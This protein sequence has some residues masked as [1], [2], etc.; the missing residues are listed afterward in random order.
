MAVSP[1]LR[2]VVAVSFTLQCVSA[3]LC[4]AGTNLQLLTGTLLSLYYIKLFNVLACIFAEQALTSNYWHSYMVFSCIDRIK[5]RITSVSIL[6]TN[7][8]RLGSRSHHPP[9]HSRGQHILWGVLR[10]RTRS[11]TK[12]Q[13]ADL[14]QGGHFASNWWLGRKMT[15]TKQ[16]TCGVVLAL[17]SLG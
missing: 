4:W 7:H 6:K 1:L 12:A 10:K 14:D 17:E 2:P 16:R 15:C 8:L 13:H 9:L 3:Y 11:I 5:A